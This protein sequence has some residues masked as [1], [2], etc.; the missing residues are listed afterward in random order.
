M[1]RD[2]LT[3]L[4]LNFSFRKQLLKRRLGKQHFTKSGFCGDIKNKS[5]GSAKTFRLNFLP[6]NLAGLY[7]FPLNTTL[8]TYI[9]HK[10]HSFHDLAL[11]AFLL[12]SFSW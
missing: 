6:W 11:Q 4:S 5:P 3:L 9:Q 7:T 2:Q 10:E 8:T 12:I 1:K